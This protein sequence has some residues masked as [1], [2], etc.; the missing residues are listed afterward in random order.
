MSLVRQSPEH[1]DSAALANGIE[2]WSKNMAI[3]DRQLEKTG[4]YVSGEQFSLAD[5]PIGLSVNRWFETPLA[6]PDFAAVKAY[7][8]RLSLRPGYVLH[9]RNGTP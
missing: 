6:H 7:Y 1:Q 4:A 2:Q 8:E 3:L 5:I 9:G